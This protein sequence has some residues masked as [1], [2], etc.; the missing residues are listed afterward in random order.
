MSDRELVR[1]GKVWKFGDNIN[2]DLIF[3][4]SAFRMPLEEQHKLV[5]SANRP[6][7]VEQVQ[8]G[9]IVIAGKDFG[10]GSGRPVGRVM[11]ECGIGGIVAE[12]VNGMALRNCVSFAMPAISCP[13]IVSLFNEGEMA[14]IDFRTGVV[15]NL[16]TGR[17]I[18]GKR[19][20]PMLADL[21]VDGGIVQM[22]VRKG[23]IEPKPTLAPVK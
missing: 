14:R 7:W 15:E 5:F 4:N 11:R 22:L 16:T 6:G 10:M 17:S 19:L 9:D 18:T 13:G 21:T 12:S 20:P 3:P 2:T 8:A 1:T 23:L